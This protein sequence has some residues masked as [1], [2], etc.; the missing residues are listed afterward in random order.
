MNLI[1]NH[2]EILS[3]TVWWL[4]SCMDRKD[5]KVLGQQWK[6][7]VPVEVVPMAYVPVSRAITRRFGGEAVL[8]MAVSKAVRQCVMIRVTQFQCLEKMIIL[9]MIMRWFKWYS[10]DGMS[11]V[12]H[13]AWCLCLEISADFPEI[14]SSH[15]DQ[16]QRCSVSST[17][18][19]ISASNWNQWYFDDISTRHRIFCIYIYTCSRF[20]SCVREVEQGSVFHV[21]ICV[22]HSP[23]LVRH[24][25]Y[26]ALLH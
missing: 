9:I 23:K 8:R 14:Y 21:H 13:T 11:K 4:I 18:V 12:K 25:A 3:C 7:G 15:L 24:H 2:K 1:L 10:L 17:V 6:K 22:K 19:M 26:Y 20:W 5:S 16:A